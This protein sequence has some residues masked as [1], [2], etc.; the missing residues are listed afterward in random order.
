MSKELVNTKG[1]GK[2]QK[3]REIGPEMKGGD[4]GRRRKRE[5]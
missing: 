3:S 2:I 4:G 1:K 5:G